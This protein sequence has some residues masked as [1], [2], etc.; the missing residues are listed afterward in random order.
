MN[1]ALISKMKI[2]F[3]IK[4][5]VSLLILFVLFTSID[6]EKLGDVIVNA[7]VMILVVALG[8]VLSIRFV[9]AYRWQIVLRLYSVYPRFWNLLSIVFI[10]NS[11]GHLLPGGIG[12]DVVRSYQLSKQEGVV[13][14][15]VASVF[16]DRVV[17]LLSMLLVAFF[18]AFLGFLFNDLSW[19]YLV[20]TGGGLIAF[21]AM[22]SLRKVLARAQYGGLVTKGPLKFALSAFDKL[23]KSLSDVKLPTKVVLKLLLLSILVQMIRVLVFFLVFLALDV[24]LEFTLLMVFIP[25]LFI[26]MLMPVSIGGLGVREGALFL[27]LNPYGVSIEACTA[28]GLLFHLLQIISLLPGVLLYF[29]KK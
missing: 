4:A 16:V 7:D 24:Q 23:V 3:F 26:V 22:Y 28:A 11:V 14:G 21:F 12:V 1:Y 25:L 29:F 17:G 9:M 20:S 6:V 19:I 5:F 2:K 27:F 13:A 15:I 18:A 8:I 10:S